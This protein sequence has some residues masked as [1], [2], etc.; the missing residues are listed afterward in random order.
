MATT[1]NT[2]ENNG[3]FETDL[4]SIGSTYFDAD[5]VVDNKAA[6]DA[7]CGIAEVYGVKSS[8]SAIMV[9]DEPKIQVTLHDVDDEQLAQIERKIS[10]SNWSKNLIAVAGRAR[11]GITNM[12]DFALNGALVPTAGAVVQ[13]TARTAQVAG[14]A[15]VRLGAIVTDSAITEG[16]MAVRRLATDPVVWKAAGSVKELGSDIKSG[17]TSLFGSFGKGNSSKFT[18]RNK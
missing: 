11:D 3:V 13:A 12:G 16:R 8:I 14:V 6:A 9:G 1:L 2:N 18:R 15:A 5:L 17:L 10:I 7:V 4:E